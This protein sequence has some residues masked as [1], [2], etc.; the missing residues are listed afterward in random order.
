[1]KSSLD[2]QPWIIVSMALLT[3]LSAGCGATVGEPNPIPTEITAPSL[4]EL[5]P[6]VET[7]ATSPSTEEAA[8]ELA[9]AGVSSN[10]DWMPY[11]REFDGV[12]MALVPAGCFKMGSIAGNESERPVHE[13]R[14]EEPFWIDVYE[15][16]NEQYGSILCDDFSSAPDQPRL[17]LNWTDAQA[18]CTARGARLPTEAEWEYAARGPDG[19]VYPW[20]NEFDEDKAVWGYNAA[21]HPSPVGSKPEGVSWIGAYDMAGNVWEWVNDWHSSNY[22]EKLPESVINPQGPNGGTYHAMRGSSFLYEKADGLRASFRDLVNP[23]VDDGVRC[24][25]SYAP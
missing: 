22:Y 5:P 12:L 15:V 19:L 9:L 11:T 18:Y 17:C 16:T 3:G 2:N 4:T 21:R 6:S 10:A 24:A 14:F 23:D 25:R 7:P 13:V 20:G 1:M 8:I